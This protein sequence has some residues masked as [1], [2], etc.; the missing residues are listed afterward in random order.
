MQMNVDGRLARPAG[1]RMAALMSRTA[2]AAILPA[3]AAA[4]ETTAA[5]P[6][7]LQ[8]IVVEGAVADDDS[9]SI[10]ATRTAAGTG[11]PTDILETLS[12][13]HI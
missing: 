3:A 9:A 10:V 6:V 7:Q 13:I 2:L 4:Q 5:D 1:R 8:P 11:L 12:L